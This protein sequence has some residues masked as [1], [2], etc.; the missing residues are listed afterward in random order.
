LGYDSNDVVHLLFY[1]KV[2]GNVILR[3]LLWGGF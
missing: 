2:G 3:R 1:F